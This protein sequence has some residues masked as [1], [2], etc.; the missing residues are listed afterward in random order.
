LAALFLIRMV[1]VFIKT[2]VAMMK[3]KKTSTE[4][5]ELILKQKC[6]NHPKFSIIVPAR[7][8]ADVVERT[9]T[10]LTQLNYPKDRFEIVVI[11]DEK[12]T[13]NN[14]NKEITTQEVIQE[15]I[16]KLAN[17]PVKI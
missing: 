3:I 10:K 11:T 2:K 1:Y 8:E 13:L 5:L 4:E 16:I 6:R 17:Q 15:T 12:E 9:I 7:N 14:V